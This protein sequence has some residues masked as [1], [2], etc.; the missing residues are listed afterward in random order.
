MTSTF[1]KGKRNFEFEECASVQN[2]KDKKSKIGTTLQWWQGL[3][4]ALSWYFIIQIQLFYSFQT[5][6]KSLT[7]ITVALL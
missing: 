5:Q 4:T 3:K 2:N 1:T 6:I 7:F